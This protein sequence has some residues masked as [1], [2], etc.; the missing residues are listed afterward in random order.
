MTH[1]I[2]HM[3][4]MGSLRDTKKD[5]KYFDD[6]TN[7]QRILRAPAVR[8]VYDAKCRRPEGGVGG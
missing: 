1:I 4:M 7:E 2:A 3:G 6:E 5:L 8:A